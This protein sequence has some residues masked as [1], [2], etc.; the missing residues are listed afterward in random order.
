MNAY[1]GQAF[2]AF[3]TVQ[4][5]VREEADKI[6]R[7]YLMQQMTE[8]RHQSNAAEAQKILLTANGLNPRVPRTLAGISSARLSTPAKEQAEA[9]EAFMRE[10][11]LEP[12]GFVLWV[13]SMIADLI[14]DKERTE[15]FESAMQDL[16]SMLGFG[17]QRPDKQYKDGGPDNLWALAS[18]NSLSSSA[19]AAWT[20]TAPRFRRTTAINYSAQS[21]GSISHT[22]RRVQRHPCWS[23]RNRDSRPRRRRLPMCEC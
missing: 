4:E 13:H 17:S 6:V 8:Y 3:E 14:W 5:A 12:N 10:R 19:K 7:G 18:C 11:F 1:S 16:G 21:H 2:A 22:T 9:A 23:I 15:Q 20:T